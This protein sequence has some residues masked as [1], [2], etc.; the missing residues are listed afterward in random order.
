LEQGRQKNPK[1]P[2]LWLVWSTCDRVRTA[3]GIPENSGKFENFFQGPGKLL[4]IL[5]LTSTP[6]NR[7]WH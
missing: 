2:E 3:P 6:G 5:F 1:C 4:E 7:A